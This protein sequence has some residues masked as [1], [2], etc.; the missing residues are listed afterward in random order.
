MIDQLLRERR[1]NKASPVPYYYQIAQALREALDSL[2]RVPGADEEVALPSEPALAEIFGVTRGT[3]RHALQVL[4]HE[5]LIHREKGRGTFARRRRVELDLTELSSISEQ[6]RSRNWAPAYRLLDIAR[7]RPLPPVPAALGIAGDE[8][9]WAVRRLRLADG[10]PVSFEQSHFPCRLVPHLDREDLSGS[11]Y[12]L[13]QSRYGFRLRTSDQ[14][15]RT[16]QADAEE[17]RLLTIRQGDPV[18]AITGIIS[19]AG[20]TPV[21]YSRS[22]WRGDRYDLQVRLVSRE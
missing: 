21:E 22:V 3:V 1:I 14:T 4:E 20:G 9:V 8:P 15:I 18:F 7:T 10:E 19:D 12:D 5:G 17:A 11:L 6:M 16:R 13:L 2:R